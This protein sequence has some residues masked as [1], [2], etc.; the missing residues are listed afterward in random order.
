MEYLKS[1]AGRIVDMAG[2][3]IRKEIWFAW[4]PVSVP[5][6]GGWQI[7]WLCRVRR[8]RFL[9]SYSYEAISNR[10]TGFRE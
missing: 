2:G 7:R 5:G 3:L 8:T 9:G 6:R 10:W 4:F 1:T